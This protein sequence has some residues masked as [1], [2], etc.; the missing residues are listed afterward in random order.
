[1]EEARDDMK[2]T[3]IARCS[4]I[5]GRLADSASSDVGS[6][7]GAPKARSS[8]LGKAYTRGR[9]HREVALLYIP[10]ANPV[11]AICLVTSRLRVRIRVLQLEGRESW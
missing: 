10:Q 3:G 1:M 9:E 6:A 4:T 5:L 11:C 8:G 7:R 2:L